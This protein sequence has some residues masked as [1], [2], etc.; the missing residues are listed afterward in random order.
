M[1]G[2]A[3]F[4]HQRDLSRTVRALREGGDAAVVAAA[5]GLV[6]AIAARADSYDRNA[7]FPARDF[8]ELWEAGI[9]LLSLPIES[10]GVGASLFATVNALKA[11]AGANGS[12][13]FLLK[14]HLTRFREANSRW[15]EPLR[16]QLIDEILTGP[17][18]IAGLRNEAERGSPARGGIPAT[19][20]RQVK[21]PDGT[22]G[23]S[24]SGHKVYGSGS[25]ASKW[26]AV[27]AATAPEDGPVRV[28]SFLV[29]AGT[30]GVSIIE[31]SWDQVG[32]RATA[33]NDVVFQD[34]VIPFDHVAGLTLFQGTDPLAA[35]RAATQVVDW[36][37][38][39][40]AGL[41]AGIAEAARD[42][43]IP[44]LRNRVPGSLGRPL[45]TVERIQAQMGEIE[46]L[47]YA[48]RELIDNIARQVDLKSASPD[49]VGH[50]VTTQDTNL[51]KVAVV[52]NAIAAV[53]IAVSLVG[54]PGLAY[55]HPIQRF[56]R[57]VLCGRVHEPQSDVILLDRG[58][59]A[60]GAI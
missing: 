53:D 26:L 21:L 12:T 43:L 38:V 9:T 51:V 16:S 1:S 33:S 15:S 48:N 24:I 14:W 60:L 8:D 19:T 54:N 31:G 35:R 42:W 32:M 50:S 47:L 39:L 18:L 46:L 10:G 3:V 11:V 2:A 7:E 30:P 22:P 13:G 40:E 45:S 36:G 25:V 57:D 56:Y 41:Y 29:P 59:K 58:R 28:G 49:G 37:S 20:A 5:Q 55:R 6:P 34:A 52:R 4:Q 27:W 23:W 17:T 44:Y